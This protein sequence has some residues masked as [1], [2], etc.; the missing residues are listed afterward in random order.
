MRSMSDAM[1]RLHLLLHSKYFCDWPLEVR[2]FCPNVYRA[3]KTC[4]DKADG[5]VPDSISIFAPP[6]DDISGREIASSARTRTFHGIDVSNRWLKSYREKVISVLGEVGPT[7][8]GV[9][10][11]AL[12]LTDNLIVVCSHERCDFTSHIMCL[13][14]IFLEQQDLHDK[15]LPAGGECPKC[16]K[17]VEW[18]TLMREVSLRIRGKAMKRGR[19][20]KVAESRNTPSP[21]G[22]TSENSDT[23][24][25]TW[26]ENHGLGNSGPNSTF[27]EWQDD[28]YPGYQDSYDEICWQDNPVS[29]SADPGFWPGDGDNLTTGKGGS[30]V[31]RLE[32]KDSWDSVIIVN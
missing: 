23:E 8:C 30:N 18:S 21:D 28:R 19:K 15:I 9:C 26:R 29:E 22:D 14:S 10:K 31:E 20:G 3:W 1:T 4:S 12:R 7:V 5:L 2:F 32:A 6:K 13:A 27:D 25:D 24:S 17:K 11:Q 16:K